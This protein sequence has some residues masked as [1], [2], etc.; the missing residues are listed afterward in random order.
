[1][2]NGPSPLG[3]VESQTQTEAMMGYDIYSNVLADIL[4]EPNLSLPLN[5]GLYAKW[6]S[7][8]SFLLNRMKG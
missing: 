4:C 5:I 2:W 7:G 6:G 1:M 8:K 3:P